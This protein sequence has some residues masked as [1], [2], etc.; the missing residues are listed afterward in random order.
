M[1]ADHQLMLVAA[2]AVIF[3]RHAIQ[4]TPRKPKII[5]AH[6]EGSGTAGET[7]S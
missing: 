4:P 6:V 1:R 3:R 2:A 5:M 7:T